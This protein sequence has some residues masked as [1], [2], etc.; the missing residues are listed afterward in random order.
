MSGIL[1]MLSGG[2]YSSAPI[3]TVAPVVSGT[4]TVGQT[5]SSTT[6]TWTGAPDPTFTYQWQR[7]GSNIG[8]A[9]SSTYTLVNADAG[10][11]IRCVVTATNVVAAVSANSNA[12]SAVAAIAPGAPTIGTATA[13]GSTTATVSFSAP[14]DNGGAT[15]TNYVV[16][17]GGSGSGASSPISVT[18]LSAA[19]SYTFTVTA[20][21]SAGTSA[22]SSASNSITT[23]IN[24]PGAV[25]SAFQ[26]GYYAGQIAVGGGGTATHYLVVSDVS[27]GQAQR[28]WGPNLNNTGVTS[29]INGPSNSA[30]LAAL[31]SG[32]AAATFCEN[33]NTGG[34]TD[35]YLG[36]LSEMGVIYYYLKPETGNNNTG[37]GS[38]PYAVSPQPINTN[39]SAGSPA[40]T[41][42]TNFRGP[43]FQQA[44]QGNYYWVSTDGTNNYGAYITNFIDGEQILRYKAS[45]NFYVRAI[46]RVPI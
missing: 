34:Y 41:T 42:A 44:F 21:N 45:S 14:A 25:G 12:T 5:L 7:A 35:W 40:Q 23:S 24:P 38:N 15:I 22:S 1:S 32:Y 9:T 27:T 13:T 28:A 18:G 37:Y 6:G 4:A 11:A 19:T 16:S 20:T 8:S 36:A 10:S 3:N 46:R 2:T 31:D 39:Y 30:T 33:L 26:G 29:T 17:G 43:N